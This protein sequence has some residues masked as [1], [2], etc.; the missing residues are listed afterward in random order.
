MGLRESSHAG[1]IRSSGA[2]PL[3]ASSAAAIRGSSSATT[4][5]ATHP[6][7]ATGKSSGDPGDRCGKIRERWI[8]RTLSPRTP[9]VVQGK[10]HRLLALCPVK[11]IPRAWRAG[12]TRTLPRF[13]DPSV[14]KTLPS[15]ERYFFQ[16]RREKCLTLFLDFSIVSDVIST[17]PVPQT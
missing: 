17:E 12:H 7:A 4:H 11:T 13:S 9:G 8:T 2:R 10:A 14:T 15:L 5:P 16:M 3:K 1:P 6:T